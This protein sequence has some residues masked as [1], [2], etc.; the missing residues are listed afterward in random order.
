M[1]AIIFTALAYLIGS[2][3]TAIIVCQLMKLPDPRTE[4]SKNPG[5]TNVL[6]IAGRN[7]ALIVLGADI[8]KG[9]IAV[10][11][12]AIFGIGG[13]GLGFVALGATLGH[14]FPVFYGF[15]GGKGVATALGGILGLSFPIGIVCGVTWLVTVFITR[16]ASLSSLIAISIAPILLLFINPGYF[17]PVLLI[18][19]VV[20][21]R[22]LENIARLRLG[23]ENKMDLGNPPK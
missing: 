4:G 20:A 18:A 14:I 9:L 10:W 1:L 16:Y 23:T 15:Q 7:V 5:A 11:I 21:W 13:F 12:A 8:L 2:V 22:H 6:R 3:N 17:V 19:G